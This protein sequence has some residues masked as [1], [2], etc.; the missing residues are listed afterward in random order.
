MII[1]QAVCARVVDD[2]LIID[3]SLLI[4]KRIKNSNKASKQQ[5]IKLNQIHGKFMAPVYG[6]I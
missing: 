6:K 5:I 1:I 3:Y 2:S 4:F